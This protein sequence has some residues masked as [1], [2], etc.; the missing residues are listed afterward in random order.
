MFPLTCLTFVSVSATCEIPPRPT[1][2]GNIMSSPHTNVSNGAANVTCEKGYQP[3]F[4]SIICINGVWNDTAHSCKPVQCNF[5]GNPENGYYR[6]GNGSNQAYSS[7]AA[8]PFGS[9]I[10]AACNDGYESSNVGQTRTCQSNKT[11]SGGQEQICKKIKCPDP[12]N[13]THGAYLFKNGSQY[14]SGSAFYETILT[15]NC[16]REYMTETSVERNCT[17]DR[18][19][20]G[21]EPV[22]KIVTCEYPGNISKGYYAFKVAMEQGTPKSYAHYPLNVSSE[23][24]LV[25][26]KGNIIKPPEHS[27]RRCL[28][29]GKWSGRSP[30]CVPVKCKWP[31]PFS[32]GNYVP[33]NNVTSDGLAY[34]TVL[35]ATCNDMFELSDTHQ[36]RHCNEKGAWDGEPAV[37][38]K[39][40]SCAFNLCV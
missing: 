6:Y 19:W 11:W 10:I 1:H 9:V 36:K 16:S 39:F 21:K 25:C 34:K 4:Y 14:I 29:S 22:C 20:S 40:L 27:V 15:V 8:L 23:I 13:I 24:Q 37:C 3:P 2:H 30:M 7:S 28:E 12:G 33:S 5:P 18:K 17:S 38:G 32:G 26:L 31:L 35:T